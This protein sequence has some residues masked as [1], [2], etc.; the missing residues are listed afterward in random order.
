MSEQRTL[1]STHSKSAERYCQFGDRRAD[2]KKTPT[3]AQIASESAAADGGTLLWFQDKGRPA[4]NLGALEAHVRARELVQV[5][6]GLLLR[7]E[8]RQ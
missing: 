3:T 1:R 4:A 6:D 7:L 5:P 8:P 2:M